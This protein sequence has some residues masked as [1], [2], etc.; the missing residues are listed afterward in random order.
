MTGFGQLLVLNIVKYHYQIVVSGGCKEADTDLPGDCT[1]VAYVILLECLS[2]GVTAD[3]IAVPAAS[4]GC[5]TSRDDSACEVLSTAGDATSVDV[6][7][8]GVR[9]VICP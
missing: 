8:T 1:T 9:C 5:R 3:F 4:V 6:A 2:L 7:D